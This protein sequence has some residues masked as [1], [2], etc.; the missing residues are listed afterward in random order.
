MLAG[1]VQCV[2]AALSACEKF[3][4]A[5]TGHKRKIRG[6]IR[7]HLQ[8]GEPRDYLGHLGPSSSRTHCT[9]ARASRQHAR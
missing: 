3:G 4:E 9:L 2:V 5:P 7:H 1:G 8:T 6:L